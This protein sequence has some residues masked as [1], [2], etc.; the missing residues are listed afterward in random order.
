M[1]GRF[2][3]TLG[4]EEIGR[5]VGKPLGVQIRETVGT[6]VYNIAPTDPV[7]AIV[8]PDGTPEARALRWALVPEWA[9]E[10]KTPRP[11]INAQLEGVQKT[12]RF[13]GVPADGPHRALIVAD[14]FIEWVK[15]EQKA[16]VKP[17]PFG[18]AVDDGAAFCFAG[19]WVVNE[20]VLGGPV[21]SCTILT[22]DSQPNRKVA[23]IHDRMPVILTDPDDWLTWINPE[24][25]GKDALSICGAL[26]AERMSVRPL[27]PTFNDARNKAADIL[28]A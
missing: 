7:L 23:P 17:A 3:N 4:P 15:A 16:K 14:E 10:V 22:C 2:T 27:P 19:L 1:C 21:A 6:S 18:F 11:Y 5:Q 12:G 24:V 20:R 26:P 28:F 8:A 13:Y 9:K 25:S